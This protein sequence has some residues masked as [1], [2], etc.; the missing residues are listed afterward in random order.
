MSRLSIEQLQYGQDRMPDNTH[1]EYRSKMY[2][3]PS[4]FEGFPAAAT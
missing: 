1:N 3:V 4:G 2:D